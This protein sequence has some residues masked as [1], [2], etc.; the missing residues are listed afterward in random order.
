MRK[1]QRGTGRLRGKL[2]F[3]CFSCGRFGHYA[4]KCPYKENHDKGKQFEKGRSYYKNEDN[5]GLPNEE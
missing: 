1:L 5:D 2:P 4:A 3:K